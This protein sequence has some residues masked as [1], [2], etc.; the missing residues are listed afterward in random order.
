M[1]KNLKTAM[2]KKGVT[3][4]MIAQLFSGRQPT[5]CQKM[6]LHNFNVD[7]AIKIKNAF[8]PE[9]SVEELFSCGEDQ[10]VRV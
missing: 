5:I 1:Y 6:K 7:E 2:K 3:Q 9:Y 8:F 10:G 4:G